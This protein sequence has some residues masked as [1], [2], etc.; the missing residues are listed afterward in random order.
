MKKLKN[1][2]P[3]TDWRH[4]EKAWYE[5]IYAYDDT[6]H[7]GEVKSVGEYGATMK[8]DVTGSFVTLPFDAMF[9]S[10]EFAAEALQDENRRKINEYKAAIT[11]VGELVKF[12]YDRAVCRCEEYTDWTAREAYRERT[13]ELLGLDLSD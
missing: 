7:S 10:G 3:R 9:T 13:R 8:D 11:D 12:A 1:P 6:I 4:G 5:S 2:N